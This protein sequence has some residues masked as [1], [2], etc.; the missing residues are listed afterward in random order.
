VILPVARAHPDAF[1]LLWRDAWHEPS[2]EDLAQEF[3]TYVTVYAKAILSAFISDPVR[4]EWAA[5]SAGAHLVDG[6]CHWLDE[7]D[8]ARDAELATVMSDGLRGLA[9]AWADRTES[10]AAG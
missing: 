5:R 6:I 8:A 10:A 7:G 3:R 1:R 4:L 2:F 9:R